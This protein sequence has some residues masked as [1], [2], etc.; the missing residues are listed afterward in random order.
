VI[1]LYWFLWIVLIIGAA[2]L[3]TCVAPWMIL[4]DSQNERKCPMPVMKILMNAEGS[5]ADV[6]PE[7]VIH[8]TEPFTVA[9]LPGGMSSG[10]ESV[11]FLIPLPDGRVVM[12]ETSLQLFQAAARAFAARYGWRTD[13]PD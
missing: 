8:T 13:D 3:I 10:K 2:V 1:K 4:R 6:P 12:A 5:L 7:K 9:C 11:S